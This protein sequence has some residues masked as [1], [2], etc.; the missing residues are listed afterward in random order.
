MSNIHGLGDYKDSGRSSYDTRSRGGQPPPR[1]YG[2]SSVSGGNGGMPSMNDFHVEDEGPTISLMR[3]PNSDPR[4]KVGTIWDF[5][6]PRFSVR[7]FTF[8]IS[9]I[10]IIMFIITVIVGAVKYDGAFVS[11]NTMLGPSTQTFIAMGGKWL[12]DIKKGHIWLLFTPALLHGGFI[13]LFSNLFFQFR[14]G[15]TLEKRWGVYRFIAVY[16]LTAMGAS[17]FSCVMSPDT[18]SVGASGALFGLLGAD[19]S[20]LVINREDIPDARSEACMLVFII[21]IN[22]II[23]FNSPGIDNWAHFGGWLTGLFLAVA[24]LQYVSVSE[25]EKKFRIGGGVVFLIWILLNSVLIATH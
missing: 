23:G 1:A 24:I 3:A 22:M 20:F 12:P 16:F 15:F 11:S 18:V 13:H 25:N 10:Q 7:T 14:F 17:L 9:M 2:G 5:L 6:M 19:V 21:I 8:L 4:D